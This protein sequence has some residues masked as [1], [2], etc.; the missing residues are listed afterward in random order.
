[1]VKRFKSSEGKQLIY[2]S[3]DKL[4]ELWGVDKEELDIETRYG[5]THV[6]VSGN[7]ENPPLLLFHGS[8]D[9][10]VMTWF[11]NVREFVKHY[12]VVAVDYFG[13]AGKVNRT[14]VFQKNST[15]FC[16]LIKY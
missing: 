6:I 14:R 16:G 11:P 5:K 10:S 3:Y 7:I 13:A 15:W 8:G 9:N 2:E 4:L 12:Y 1:M